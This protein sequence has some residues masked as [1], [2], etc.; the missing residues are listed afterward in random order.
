M[1][2]E[3]VSISCTQTGHIIV[4]ITED[5]Q[6]MLAEYVSISCI[7][8]AHIIVSITEDPQDMLAEYVSISCTKL[9]ILLL[10]SQSK[11]LRICLQ[12]MSAFPAHKLDILLLPS[13]S[14][15]LRICLQNMSAFPVKVLRYLRHVKGLLRQIKSNMFVRGQLYSF[16]LEELADF[17]S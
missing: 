3:Y 12:N 6:D 16:F 9:D 15:V 14:K 1:L 13:Q 2:A 7:Q 8:T 5:P 17:W 11:I 4:S 10:L